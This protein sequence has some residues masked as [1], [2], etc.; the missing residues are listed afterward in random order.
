MKYAEDL[1]KACKQL[2]LYQTL[3]DSWISAIYSYNYI[4]YYN[5]C[6]VLMNYNINV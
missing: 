6:L 2:L 1:L 4:V 5:I 3:H